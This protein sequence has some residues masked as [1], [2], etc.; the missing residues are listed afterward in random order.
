M[1]ANGS[2]R[3]HARRTRG[4]AGRRTGD[5]RGRE[6]QPRLGNAGA[7]AIA[8]YMEDGGSGNEVAG[9]RR[10][11]IDPRQTTMGS[12]SVK[13]RRLAEHLE[14]ALR[15]RQPS[16]QAVPASTPEYLPWPVA[17]YVPVQ[18]EPDGRWS[19]SAKRPRTRTSR[20]PTV[21][22]NGSSAGIT[23]HP[24]ANGYGPNTLVWDFDPGLRAGRR[25][26]HLPRRGV[27]TSWSAACQQ[28]R[29][30]RH[31]VRRRGVPTPTP[32]RRR[33]RGVGEASRCGSA[34][35]APT[36]SASDASG[37]DGFQQRRADPDA[38]ARRSAPGRARTRGDAAADHRGQ[39]GRR[40]RP[41]CLSARA[42][43]TVGNISDWSAPPCVPHP[44]R[45][46]VADRGR[47]AGAPST[48]AGFGTA[49]R[50]PRRRQ[51]A[52]LTVPGA[53]DVDRV[54]IVAHPV[55]AAAA[56]SACTSAA[57]RSGCIS[58]DGHARPSG[59]SSWCCPGSATPLDGPVQ[60]RRRVR[61][62]KKVQVD[63]V[64]VS[65]TPSD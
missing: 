40:A 61:A 14:R 18:I 37:V 2:P 17:G 42:R 39:P 34:G 43:D 27:R 13:G 47:A 26:P 25:R 21:T 54:G 63:G 7:A 35:S 52:T 46:R 58:L 1:A 3:P 24:V 60:G 20:R 15:A 64:V 12:G 10:W 11:I 32:T 49:R 44:G 16:W 29:L 59:R 28:L 5:G 33:S 50:G 31:A 9:H 30:R 56:R 41:L 45:R 23:V 48:D 4:T 55:R 22:V 65:G 62:R 36:G 19:L 57:P 38:R 6:V 8:A 51:G 53:V